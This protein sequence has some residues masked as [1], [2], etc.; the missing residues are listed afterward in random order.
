ML[1]LE[2]FF[3]T[4]APDLRRRIFL[5]LLLDSDC[6]ENDLTFKNIFYT[7]VTFFLK[8]ICSIKLI[9]I[10]EKQNILFKSQIV[11]ETIG[12]QM[13]KKQIYT[14]TFMKHLI[15]ATILLFLL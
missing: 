8:H 3:V 4:L 14:S 5:F 11:Y 13:K 10:T 9:D 1:Y 2:S 6:F 15:N 12:N 7:S